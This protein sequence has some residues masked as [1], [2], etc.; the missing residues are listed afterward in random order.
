MPTRTPLVLAL[1]AAVAFPL[2]ASAQPTLLAARGPIEAAP[3]SV[4]LSPYAGVYTAPGGTLELVEANGALRLVATG[5]PLAAVLSDLTATS[6]PQDARAEALMTAWVAGDSAPLAAAVAPDR[7]LDAEADFAASRDALIR[8]LGAMTHAEILGTFAQATGQQATLARIHF[9][10]GAQWISLVW[11]DR[12]ELATIKRGLNP[13]LAGTAR[14]V[15]RDTFA[16]HGTPVTFD[17]DTTGRIHAVMIGRQLE[18]T[19]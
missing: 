1:I 13:V 15:G 8:R 14:P 12:G 10:H 6:T 17:R 11:T 18:A 4:P 7:Q 16:I 19:R 5:A 3:I 9:E 2:A